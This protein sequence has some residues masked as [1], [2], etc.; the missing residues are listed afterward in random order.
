MYELLKEGQGA[1]SV[2]CVP[3]TLL[4]APR[5]HSVTEPNQPAALSHGAQGPAAPLDAQHFM[6][7]LGVLLLM[8]TGEARWH[9]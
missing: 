3:S 8:A 9:F 5:D 4:T 7:W 2:S 6:I 1:I